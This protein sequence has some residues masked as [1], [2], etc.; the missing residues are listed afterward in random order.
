MDTIIQERKS[1]M[2]SRID[3]L[4]MII[5]SKDTEGNG[6]GLSDTN[7]SN[8]AMLFLAAGSETTSNVKNHFS[9]V[10]IIFF[11]H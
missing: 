1:G 8:H 9:K 3:L 11:S 7:I 4:Q 5:D 2:K 10:L 6:D